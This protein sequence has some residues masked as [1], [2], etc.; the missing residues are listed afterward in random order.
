[1][2]LP[3]PTSGA[4]CNATNEL[5]QWNGVNLT[6]N[7]D[8]NLTGDGLNNY[9]WNERNQLA[10]V[11]DANT[12]ATLAS[13]VYDPF[14]RRIQNSAGDGVLYDGQ[15]AVQELSGST[16]VVN[17]P[18]G[19]V[20]EF[21]GRTDSAGTT[22]PLTDALGSTIALTD[23]S[24][25]VQTQYTYDPYGGTTAMG[26]MSTNTYQFSGRVNDGTGLYY[27]RARYYD[28]V[29]MRFISQDPLGLAGGANPYV[30]ADDSPTDMVDPMGL[31]ATAGR[32]SCPGGCGPD[33]YRDATPAEEVKELQKAESY[34]GTPYK[35][36]GKTPSGFD[37][38]GYVC[39]AIQHSI[40]PNLQYSDTHHMAANP[41][42]RP[43]G[44][45]ESHNPGD[46]QL[47]RS[48]KGFHDPNKADSA[49]SL[50]S[51]QVSRN[52]P[53]PG[54]TRGNPAWFPG[55]DQWLRPRVPCSQ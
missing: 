36:G 52:N 5:T 48:H 38:T 29:I 22:F 16:P 24:G 15:D 54:V 11:K 12:G 6:Y 20:D 33:G 17:R 34:Q 40:N 31:A 4:I 23:S 10:T 41:G 25:T 49:N 3:S 51:A 8:G 26:A 47:F 9:T 46:V 39:Y 28:P 55:T 7:Q 14:G 1:M 53:K 21:F 44:P 45:R 43:L 37:C 2:S 13:F 30:Y 42:Y 19:G 18:T 50:L 27:Y 32:N 35:W